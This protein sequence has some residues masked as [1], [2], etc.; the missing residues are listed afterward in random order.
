MFSLLYVLFLGIVAGLLPVYLGLVPLWFLRRISETWRGFLVSVSLGILLFLFADVTGE[1]LTLAGPPGLSSPLF[2]V[3]ITLGVFAPVYVAR[4]RRLDYIITRERSGDNPDMKKLG[5][6]TAYMLSVGIGMHNFGEGLAIGAAYSAGQFV[7]TSVL[8]VGFAL[9]NGTEGFGIAAPIST[10]HLKLKDPL[11]LGLIAGFPTVIGSAVGYLAYSA[12]LG[13]FFFAVA[14]G[15]LLYVIVELLRI[16]NV[17]PRVETTFAGITF[18]M[19]L[20]FGTNLLL[21][22]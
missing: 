17:Y 6:F 7:L 15:A 4:K 3:G 19:L 10:V 11:T 13:V 16:A 14:A 8:V 5:F 12:Y 20:M 1:S 2:V 21:S 9:H 22:L 18:G